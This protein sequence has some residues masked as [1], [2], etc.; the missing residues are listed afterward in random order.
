MP[1]RTLDHDSRIQANDHL[2]KAVV[3]LLAIRDPEFINQL[4]EIF[5]VARCQGDEISNMDADAWAHIR[6][7]LEVVRT[8]VH[9]DDESGLPPEDGADQVQSAA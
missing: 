9:G 3:A 7:E 8:F 5:L 6:E 1:K 4:D 2:L